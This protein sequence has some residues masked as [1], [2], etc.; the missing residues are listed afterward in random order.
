MASH[1]I[2]LWVA[3]ERIDTVDAFFLEQAYKKM[4]RLESIW[5]KSPH[6]F[7]SFMEQNHEWMIDV[8]LPLYLTDEEQAVNSWI[9]RMNNDVTYNNQERNQLEN[10]DLEFTIK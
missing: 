5:K 1:L 7:E 4:D 3:E 8:F 6:A 10:D 2:E 9:A